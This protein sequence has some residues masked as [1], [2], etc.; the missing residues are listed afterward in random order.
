MVA[1]FTKNLSAVKVM[2]LLLAASDPLPQAPPISRPLPPMAVTWMGPL[3]QC[4]VL[5]AA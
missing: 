5:F 4:F 2:L 3:V 1:G